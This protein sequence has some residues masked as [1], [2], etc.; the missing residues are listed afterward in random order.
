MLLS[1]CA[2]ST[3]LRRTFPPAFPH[4]EYARSLRQA[5]LDRTALGR[6]WLA[7]AEGALETALNVTLPY[8]ET[9]RCPPDEAGAAAYRFEES[10]AASDSESK[11]SWKPAR[12]ASSS[13]ICFDTIPA[14]TP[15]NT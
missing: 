9:G 5:G 2:P 12:R 7:A 11:W 15:P 14:R 1:A 3:V 4:E 10:A 6:D 13:S 8:R